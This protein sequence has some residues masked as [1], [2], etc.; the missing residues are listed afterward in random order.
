MTK[1]L[2]GKSSNSK[3]DN[4]KR[5]DLLSI[6]TTT[7]TNRYH[8]YGWHGNA[9]RINRRR[10]FNVIK[11]SVSNVFTSDFAECDCYRWF[12]EH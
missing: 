5:G 4:A 1:S 9:G 10:V 12:L 11:W 8:C 3:R 6:A 7:D 2:N